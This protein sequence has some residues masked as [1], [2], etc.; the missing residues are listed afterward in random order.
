MIT[1]SKTPA[2]KRALL[3]RIASTLTSKRGALTTAEMES[4][5]SIFEQFEELEDQ[6]RSGSDAR[7]NRAFVSWLRNGFDPTL[8]QPGIG[9]E[10][11][12][13]LLSGYELAGP[14]AGTFTPNRRDMGAGGESAYPGATTGF[15]IP[16]A[17][18]GKV[19]SA[20]KFYSRLLA[21]ADLWNTQSGAPLGYP[22]DNDTSSAGEM[23]P[24]HGQTNSEDIPLSLTNLKTFKF[25]SRVVKVSLELLQDAGFPIDAYLPARFGIRLAR[26]MNPRFT[27]GSG[28]GEPTGFITAAAVGATATGSSG[29]DGSAAGTNTIGTDDLAALEESVDPAYR[30]GAVFMLHGNTLAALR[31][32]KD[33]SGRPAFPGLHHGGQDTILNYP[34]ELNSDMDQLPAMPSSPP[35]A[36]KTVAFGRFDKFVIRRAPM[37]LSRM[38]TRWIDFG[39]IAYLLWQR[40]DSALVDGG[41]GAIKVL[42]NV[43]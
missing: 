18:S 37:I 32:V 30:V 29:N 24:E 6:L 35:V 1:T 13:V 31:R 16:T 38:E 33:R 17:F 39:Q 14:S 34:V 42:Q 36:R 7:Y 43:Y 5:R 40:A 27:Y 3:G 8:H 21:L 12:A 41:G 11:R 10:H 26:A 22:T 23:I 19:E 28:N 25:G 4:L 20:M 2:E 15:F 9:P